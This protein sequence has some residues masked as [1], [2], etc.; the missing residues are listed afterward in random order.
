MANPTRIDRAVERWLDRLDAGWR[1]AVADLAEGHAVALGRI[2]RTLRS[3]EADID[4]AVA[5]GVEPSA[6]WLFQRDR[7]HALEVQVRAEITRTGAQ[8]AELTPVLRQQG[9]ETGVDYADDLITV[10]NP[11]IGPGIESFGRLPREAVAA[12]VG[13]L[14]ADPLKAVATSID[15]LAGWAVLRERLVS[16]IAS[17][18]SFRSIARAMVGQLSGLTFTRAMTITRTEMN[19]SYRE[20]AR[21][22]FG[23]N[24]AVDRWVWRAAIAGSRRGPCPV[25][26]GKHGSVHPATERL[27]SHPNCRCA[28][29][30]LVTGQEP[31]TGLTPVD[32]EQYVR[33]LSDRERISVLGPTRAQAWERGDLPLSA[34]VED[35]VDPSWGVQPRL[36]RLRDLI[37]QGVVTG[38]TTG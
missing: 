21:I 7:Y 6:S 15:P 11:Q 14:Q 31:P 18:Q 8:V 22:R 1:V 38:R 10:A 3:L 36:V 26:L 13:F 9:I 24:P 32:A 33:S 17:G 34:M 12:Q 29:V 30:P 2:S 20:A 28:P 35:R 4:L 23:A 27:S 5:Q 37:T 19:R 16:G 25:C